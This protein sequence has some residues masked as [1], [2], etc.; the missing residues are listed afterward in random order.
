MTDPS[1]NLTSRANE[2][3]P[4]LKEQLKR[5]SRERI[6]S[7]KRTAADQFAEIAD[8]LDTARA[9]LD[10]SQPTLANYTSKLAEGVGRIATRLREDS[11]EDMYHDVRRFASEH[12]QMFL[13]GGVAIGLLAARFIKAETEGATTDDMDDESDDPGPMRTQR[14]TEASGLYPGGV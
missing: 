14:T 5:D 6:E 4:G 2:S 10:Q 8:A 12:P 9:Q 7:G 1:D 13:L 3:K 11:I